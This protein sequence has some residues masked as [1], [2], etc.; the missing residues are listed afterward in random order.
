L[1][2]AVAP[3][4]AHAVGAEA[5]LKGD[6]VEI[7]AYFDDDTPAADARVSVED[8]GQRTVAEGRTDAQG[9]WL[10]PRPAA[11]RYRVTVDAG[12]GHRARIIVTVP[13]GAPAETSSA[14]GKDAVTVSEGPSRQEFTRFPWARVALGLAVI[15]LA[16]LGLY[17]LRR[18]AHPA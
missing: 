14:A 9:R 15:A 1:L 12:A 2:G 13:D 17:R 18:P 3:A 16:A 10:F 4:S 7:E 11:G 8:E 6:R 5:R